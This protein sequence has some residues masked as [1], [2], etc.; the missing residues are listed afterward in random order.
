MTTSVRDS[1]LAII[2][3]QAVLEVSDLHDT[4]TLADLG[5]DIAGATATRA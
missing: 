4:M 3:E 1:V 2:A 5:L